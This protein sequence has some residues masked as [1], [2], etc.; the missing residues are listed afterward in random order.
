MENKKR[1]E[2]KKWPS[3]VIEVVEIATC[4]NCGKKTENVRWES[5]AGTKYYKCPCCKKESRLDK[6]KEE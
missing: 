4:Y 5:H 6:I 2:P 3:S 1:F